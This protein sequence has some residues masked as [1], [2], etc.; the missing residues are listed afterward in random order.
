MLTAQCIPHHWLELPRWCCTHLAN[1]ILPQE[2]PLEITRPINLPLPSS[3]P[4]LPEDQSIQKLPL[5]I[6]EPIN[7]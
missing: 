3:S 7:L 5:E 6:A 1:F 2:L 4:L